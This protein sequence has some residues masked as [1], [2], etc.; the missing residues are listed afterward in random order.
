V[1]RDPI[2]E[3]GGVNVYGFVGNASI[4]RIDLLGLEW[5]APLREHGPRAKVTCKPCD[6]VADLAKKI[7]LSVDD[8]KEWLKPV[9]DA[10]IPDDASDPIIGGNY[11]YTVPNE[12][13]WT[14]GN[15]QDH[16]AFG[17]DQQTRYIVE[18][19]KLK[20]P[21]VKV[22]RGSWYY[23][24]LHHNR[25]DTLEEIQ[26]ILKSPDL[27]I[28][29]HGGHG[30]DARDGRLIINK[31]DKQKMAVN[32]AGL[33]LN[34]KLA[35]VYLYSCYAAR[36]RWRTT[37]VA[38]SIDGITHKFWASREAVSAKLPPGTDLTWI[39]QIPGQP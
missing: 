39:G 16:V 18:H 17:T 22:R 21:G 2:E 35:E 25:G 6:K 32:H 5:S 3:E 13:A 20:Y 19:V 23:S 36:G 10:L 1:N 37:H 4:Y 12:V 27:Y 28:W 34:H 15:V 8:Y 7:G 33:P 30:S 14:I 9:G 29:V 38:P 26:G 31:A 24:W 11:T